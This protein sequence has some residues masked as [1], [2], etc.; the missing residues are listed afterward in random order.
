MEL[1]A[2][3]PAPPKDLAVLLWVM[4]FLG[5]YLNWV[6]FGWFFLGFSLVGFFMFFLGVS[7]GLLGFQENERAKDIRLKTVWYE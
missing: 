7:S 1:V 2:H 4:V 6:F 3:H 5:F